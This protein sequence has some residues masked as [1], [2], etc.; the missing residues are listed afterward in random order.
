ME[1]EIQNIRK[2]KHLNERNLTQLLLTV[3]NKS[4]KVVKVHV[5][6]YFFHSPHMRKKHFLSQTTDISK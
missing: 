3:Q 4:G 2:L 6:K 1:S 5:I